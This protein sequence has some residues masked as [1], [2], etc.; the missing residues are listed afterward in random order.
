MK[1]KAHKAFSLIELSIVMLIIGIIIAGVTQSSRL[2]SAY[3]LIAARNQTKNSPV[4]SISN[5]VLWLDAA[6]ETS[7]KDNETQ[8][9]YKISIWKDISSSNIEKNDAQQSDASLRPTYKSNCINYL[10]CLNFD[11][12]NSQN[13]DINLNDIINSDYTIFFVESRRSGK[14]D[15]YFLAGDD[16]N[17][18][19]QST[20]ALG[21]DRTNSFTMS[22]GGFCKFSTL[23]Y[24]SDA[25]PTFTTPIARVHSDIFSASSE[26]GRY[27][28]VNG[29]LVRIFFDHD[30][31]EPFFPL[32]SYNSAHIGGSSVTGYFHG[33]ISEVIIF[34]TALKIQ[35]R[36]AIELYL[37]A[38]WGVRIAL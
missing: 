20:L 38:K 22:L 6:S 5:I 1:R 25:I 14:N 4:A 16:N 9:G 7:L 10:P 27:H 2:I 30:D 13:L 24:S 31:P 15:S 33:D 32:L 18:N 23:N 29:Q 19:C 37:G 17:Y 21:Y 8:D 11:S 12:T 3:K 35:E 28:Y 36:K 34:R 26:Y